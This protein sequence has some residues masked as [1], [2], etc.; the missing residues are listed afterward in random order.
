MSRERRMPARERRRRPTR[1]AGA[2]RSTDRERAGPR[3][4][5]PEHAPRNAPVPL[6]APA[7]AK[8]LL[9]LSADS[10]RTVPNRIGPGRS[11]SLQ[12][13]RRIGGPERG[14]RCRPQ[15]AAGARRLWPPGL[16]LT[17]RW[18]VTD[19]PRTDVT[20]VD[21]ER[22]LRARSAPVHRLVRRASPAAVRCRTSGQRVLR[23]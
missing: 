11:V 20:V 10:P 1:Y 22:R 4:A 2:P 12:G 14:E 13:A 7:T 3:H 15:P 21:L 5:V 8:C 18:N 23:P 16:G 6:A 19:T 9:D 17:W